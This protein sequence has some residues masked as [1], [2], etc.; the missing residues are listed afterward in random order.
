MLI[1]LI[2][3]IVAILAGL[4]AYSDKG[5]FSFKERGINGLVWCIVMGIFT[6]VVIFFVGGI[7][8][9][10]SVGR[11]NSIESY[12]QANE[13]LYRYSVDT[14]REGI[15]LELSNNSFLDTANLKQIDSFA[16]SVTSQRDKAIRFNNQIKRTRYWEN[17][18]VIGL[19]VRNLDPDIRMITEKDLSK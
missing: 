16:D 13:G 11:V 4:L 5:D 14:L 8:F 18:I 17:N 7:V 1:L 12:A 3:P 9:L 6:L 19:F 15:P 2:I 10:V